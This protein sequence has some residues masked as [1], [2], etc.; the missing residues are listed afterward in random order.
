MEKRLLERL[1]HDKKLELA[2]YDVQ[3]EEYCRLSTQR[4]AAGVQPLLP[5]FSRG[6]L[7]A[8]RGVSA[9]SAAAAL[10]AP[11]TSSPGGVGASQ[12]QLLE[13]LLAEKKAEL[14]AATSEVERYTSLLEARTAAAAAAPAPVTA[15]GAQLALGADA[16]AGSLEERVQ[17]LEA[18]LMSELRRKEEQMALNEELL[19]INQEQVVTNEELVRKLQAVGGE[20]TAVAQA[21]APARAAPAAAAAAA[22]AARA[23][24]P[25]SGAQ[26]VVVYRKAELEAASA[27]DVAYKKISSVLDGPSGLAV[28]ALGL[29]SAI[30]PAASAAVNAVQEAV[31][32]SGASDAGS[33]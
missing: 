9:S 14:A 21:V 20:A 30:A 28:V 3:L 10:A 27:A 22:A 26:P 29:A 24:G 15:A 18:M 11:R 7:P 25:A 32:N 6:V 17:A 4:A 33:R 23:E 2:A 31:N 16:G 1:L 12:K 19:R 8:S 5:A 13:K